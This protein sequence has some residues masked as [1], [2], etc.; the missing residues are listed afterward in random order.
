LSARQAV[1]M[2]LREQVIGA[3]NL[4]RATRG[5]WPLRLGTLGGRGDWVPG[6]RW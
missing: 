4:F 3:L 1:P 2:R 6:R 5:P